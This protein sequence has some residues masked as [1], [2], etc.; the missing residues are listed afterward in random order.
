MPARNWPDMKAKCCWEMAPVT[1]KK[2][3]ATTMSTMTMPRTPT[4]HDC[5]VT[6]QTPVADADSNAGATMVTSPEQ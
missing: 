3:Q 2:T 5:V 6:G 4:C 1:A